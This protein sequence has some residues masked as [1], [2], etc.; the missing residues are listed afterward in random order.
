MQ[1]ECSLAVLDEAVVVTSSVLSER[2][3]ATSLHRKVWVYRDE[4]GAIDSAFDLRN[5]LVTLGWTTD[6][7]DWVFAEPGAVFLW[8]EGSVVESAKLRCFVDAWFRL[9]P[10]DSKPLDEAWSVYL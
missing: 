6:Q 5:C 8:K 4:V 2:G 1:V 9:Y 3:E 7:E 10:S